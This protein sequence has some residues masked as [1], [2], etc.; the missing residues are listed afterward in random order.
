ML[1]AVPD[2][3]VNEG[4]DI[5]STGHLDKAL[6]DARAQGIIENGEVD[7]KKFSDLLLGAGNKPW[8]AKD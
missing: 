5:V 4:E 2:P 1:G 7:Y 6:D 8:W 3:N